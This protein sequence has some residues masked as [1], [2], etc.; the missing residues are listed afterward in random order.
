MAR[1]IALTKNKTVPY[2]LTEN[3]EDEA[4]DQVTWKLRALPFAVR[5]EIMSTV[6]FDVAQGQGGE[7]RID[8]GRRYEKAVRWGLEGWDNLYGADGELV[9]PGYGEK[10][11]GVF[12]LADAC[13]DRL[14]DDWIIELGDQIIR[15]SSSDAETVGK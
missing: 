3:R 11:Y 9:E 6:A 8:T 15:L 2:V 13:L 14:C 12:P 10:R 1:P 5:R 7:A 4:D